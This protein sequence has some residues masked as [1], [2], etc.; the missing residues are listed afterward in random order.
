MRDCIVT[1]T[2]KGHFNFIKKYLE[3]FDKFVE[4]KSSVRVCFII[5][6]E[7]F[8]EFKV[9][10][11]PYKDS[12]N[13]EVLFFDDVLIKNNIYLSSKNLLIKYGRFSFQTLKKFYGM[14]AIDADRFL[15]LDSESS[16]LRPIKMKDMF[17]S[18]FESKELLGSSIDKERFS[19]FCRRI[20][21]N[22]DFVIGT[23]NELW[24]IEDFMWFYSKDILTNMF[25]ELGSPI[26]LVDDV[27][28]NKNIDVGIFEILL[29]RAFLYNN[30]EKYGYK[31]INVTD[32]CKAN[33]SPYVWN[34]Y[35]FELSHRFNKDFGLIEIAMMLLNKDNVDEVSKLFKVLNISIIRCEWGDTASQ[36]KFI[37]VVKPVI[38]AASQAHPFGVLSSVSTIK[39]KYSTG[40]YKSLLKLLIKRVF[41][42]LAPSYKLSL[43]IRDLMHH[44]I[45]LQNK[46]LEK[47]SAILTILN[48]GE[49]KK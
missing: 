10:I 33:L 1:P 34:N 3:S 24:F 26:E 5:D 38:F 41:I 22:I 8:S 36:E 19:E 6:K 18:Y 40:Y 32:V 30:R 21:D 42:K 37:D 20:Q 29:Y 14:L 16:W 11:E 23:K 47:Q 13:I 4:D 49:N 15:V 17:D 27:Y 12:C 35:F 39:N 2:F 7:E 46:I 25:V 31:F 45:S 44:N 28:N 48:D 9:I 43:Q